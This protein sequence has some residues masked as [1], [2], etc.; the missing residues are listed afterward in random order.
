MMTAPFQVPPVPRAFMRLIVGRERVLIA[1]ETEAQGGRATK[2]GRRRKVTQ[3]RYLIQLT[4][5]AI[6]EVKRQPR[7]NRI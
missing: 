6:R 7:T 5:C 1:E 4:T 3:S 2:K